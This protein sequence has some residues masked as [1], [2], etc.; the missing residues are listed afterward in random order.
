MN[1]KKRYF[2]ELAYHGKYYHGWQVQPNAVSVQEVLN[3][4][5]STILREEIYVIG[6]GRTDTGVHCKQQFAHCDTSS[7]LHPSDFKHKLNSFLP[8][9]ISIQKLTE[10]KPEAHARFDATFRRYEYHISL[11]KNPFATD[12]A[13][14]VT[15]MP[16]FDTMNEAANLLL[17]FESFESFCK[18]HSQNDQFKCDITQA[19]WEKTNNNTA[20][21]HIKANRFL[22]GMVRLIVGELMKV[23]T[24]K[25]S[26]AHFKESLEA[27]TSRSNRVSAPPQGLFLC[28][29]GYS[30]D[31]FVQ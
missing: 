16:N 10:V 24:G 12:L 9:D 20:I 28:E 7:A 14:E 29:V 6:S 13:W 11:A 23:G 31:I 4:K 2:I 15:K 3:Q 19:Y 5:M 25:M 21:F 17:A 22:R 26:V 30:D 8:T 27:R 1:N 18:T